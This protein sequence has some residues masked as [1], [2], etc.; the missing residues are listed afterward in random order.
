M[1]IMLRNFGLKYIFSNF[2]SYQEEDGKLYFVTENFVAR[3]LTYSYF[4]LNAFRMDINGDKIRGGTIRH[5][6]TYRQYA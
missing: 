1:H 3:K 2:P 5:V 6:E 4:I